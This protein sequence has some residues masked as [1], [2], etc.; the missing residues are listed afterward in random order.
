[1]RR[2][3]HG[4]AWPAVFLLTGALL[5]QTP[6]PAIDKA[7]IESFLRHLMLWGPQIQVSLSDPRPSG[8][9]GLYE[10]HVAAKYQQA[11]VEESFLVSADGGHIVRGS[12]FRTDQP[13]YAADAA[14]IRTEGHPAFG[15][16]DA[17]QARLQLVV[18]SDFQ[19]NFC[20]EEARSLRENLPK[21]YPGQFRL[22]FRDLPLDQIHPWARS[23]AI[24]GRCA[25]RQ[26]GD[27]FW[28]YHD[29]IFDRQSE[30]KADNLR[31]RILE[32]LKSADGDEKAFAD[33][34]DS[35]EP[36]REVAASVAEARQLHIQ[37]TPTL[38]VNGRPLTGNIPW[39]Q[40]KAI[41]DLELDFA[42]KAASAPECCSITLPVLPKQ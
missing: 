16:S 17:G 24:A 32:W 25:F 22:V 33:C 3:I 35:P 9:P 11:S 14:R 15:A 2:F 38:Y 1:M 18:F 41:L 21:A 5:A 29:W 28:K 8:I 13:P 37:S 4:Q 20:R 42:K 6:A 34:L 39:P 19:C 31:A 27:L 36:A 30:I 12:I 26:S 10:L 40:L 7:R 23:A